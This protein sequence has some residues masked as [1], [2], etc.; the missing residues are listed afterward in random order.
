MEIQDGPEVSVYR[1]VQVEVGN[2]RGSCIDEVR[3][4]IEIDQESASQALDADNPQRY[5]KYVIS[6]L[7]QKKNFCFAFIRGAGPDGKD[8]YVNSHVIPN[9]NSV[10]EIYLKPSSIVKGDK[11]WTITA[12]SGLSIEEFEAYGA[13]YSGQKTAENCGLGS[14]RHGFRFSSEEE[15]WKV[16]KKKIEANSALMDELSQIEVKPLT[17]EESLMRFDSYLANDRPDGLCAFYEHTDIVFDQDT[18]IQATGYLSQKISDHVSLRYHIPVHD[19]LIPDQYVADIDRINVTEGTPPVLGGEIYMGYRY[20]ISLKDVTQMHTEFDAETGKVRLKGNVQIGSQSINIRFTVS[21]SFGTIDPRLKG[22]LTHQYPDLWNEITAWSYN[23]FT[24]EETRR[25]M[26]CVDSVRAISSRESFI[27]FLEENQRNSLP[28][29]KEVLALHNKGEDLPVRQVARQLDVREICDKNNEYIEGLV[30]SGQAKLFRRYGYVGDD[31]D[32]GY[33]EGTGKVVYEQ[34]HLTDGQSYYI[35]TVVARDVISSYDP[36]PRYT[37]Q[38][39]SVPI[40]GG[41]DITTFD[42]EPLDFLTFDQY[43][44]SLYSPEFVDKIISRY[45]GTATDIDSHISITESYASNL[46]II[47]IKKKMA[48]FKFGWVPYVIRQDR[49]H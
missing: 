19:V 13:I 41:V 47:E 15:R 33:G 32:P 43:V 27:G 21:D 1:Y 26:T 34:T 38:Y 16:L 20:P 35:P 49:I 9:L 11:G 17:P 40:E 5:N 24:T 4:Q 48:E 45:Q 25:I 36:D 8:V 10:D 30:D 6:N 28:M 2:F 3:H 23:Q 22:F 39:L 37:Y 14:F 46:F 29:I 18:G 31:D 44:E 42:V 7:T 12:R